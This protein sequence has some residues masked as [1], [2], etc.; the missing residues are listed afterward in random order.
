MTSSRFWKE[1]E[2]EFRRHANDEN[3]SLAADWYSITDAWTFRGG[4]VERSERIFKSLARKAARGLRGNLGADPCK[5]WLDSLRDQGYHFELRFR[6]GGAYNQKRLDYLARSGEAL[7]V[8]EGVVETVTLLDGSVETRTCVEGITGTIERIFDTSADFCLELGSHAAPDAPEQAQSDVAGIITPDA[9]AEGVAEPNT[10]AETPKGSIIGAANPQPDAYKW[11]DIEICFLSDERVQIT[12]GTQTE[13]RNY[14]EMGFGSKKNGTP[15]LAWNTLRTM[16]EAGGRI[17]VAADSSKWAE[18]E[19]R[20][21]EIRKV[22]RHRFRLADDP[23]AY[24]K[25]SQQN[26]GRFGYCAKFKLGCHSSY[27]F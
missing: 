16:A 27:D 21:Q 25:K 18:V 13:T 5:A 8:V 12:M 1:R 4:S 6:Q 9:S 22:L 23:I 19:K 3:S 11:E 20:I 10:P 2:E 26:A 17:A 24:F 7:P 14:A 15:V